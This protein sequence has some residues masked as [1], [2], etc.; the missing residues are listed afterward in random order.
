MNKNWL[1]I[2]C[3]SYGI[4]FYELSKRSGVAQSTL[5][6][7]RNK[8]ISVCDIKFGTAL[9]ISHGFGMS[10]TEFINSVCKIEFDL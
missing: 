4:T 2:L 1:E 10:P 3:E 7:I 8:N 6:N 9:S 5:S